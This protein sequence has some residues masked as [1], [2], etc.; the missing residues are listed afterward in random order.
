[1]GIGDR[2]SEKVS[3]YVSEYSGKIKQLADVENLE[4]IRQLTKNLVSPDRLS[5]FW[6]LK[7]FSLTQVPLLFLVQPKV[8]KLD[9]E[10]CE[11]RVNLN[12]ITK[13][14]LNSIY[15][16]AQAIGADAVVGLPSLFY[17]RKFEGKNIVPVFKSFKADFLKRAEGDLLFVC[18]SGAQIN[19]MVEKACT[20]GERVTEDVAAEAQLVE[21][22]EVVSQFVL[23]LSL[24]CKS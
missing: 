12:F 15:F 13:N 7:L 5:P 23:G 11:I 2:W 20:T 6:Q 24:K 14:H 10:T 18:N 8:Q 3:E 19:A 17:A 1:M 4:F 16:G 21:S 9:E 22:G